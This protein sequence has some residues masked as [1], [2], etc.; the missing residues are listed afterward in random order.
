M[1]VCRDWGIWSLAKINTNIVA[2]MSREIKD[3]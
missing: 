1:D 3:G 2:K